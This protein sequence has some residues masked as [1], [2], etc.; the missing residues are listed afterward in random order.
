MNADQQEWCLFHLHWRV[1]VQ[2]ITI[3][4]EIWPRILRTTKSSWR[5]HKQRAAKKLSQSQSYCRDSATADR[6]ITSISTRIPMKDPTKEPETRSQKELDCWQITN[7]L[8]WT[9]PLWTKCTMA[10][11]AE[12]PAINRAK[13]I[14]NNWETNQDNLIFG[15]KVII[16]LYIKVIHTISSTINTARVTLAPPLKIWKTDKASERTR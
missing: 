9:S 4:N 8:A 1:H 5:R 14:F 6:S 12:A 2:N 11:A 13:I 10:A 15:F 7:Q 3:R 16:F